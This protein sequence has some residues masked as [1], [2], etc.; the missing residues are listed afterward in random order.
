[1]HDLLLLLDL[2][3]VGLRLGVALPALVVTML[4]IRALGGE[5]DVV[6]E[7]LQVAGDFGMSQ[8]EGPIVFLHIL[9]L[10]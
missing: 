9:T 10:F 1:M 4:E 2:V 5:L 3:H 6:E 7:L 8:P